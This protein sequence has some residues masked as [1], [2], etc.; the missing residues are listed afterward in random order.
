MKSSTILTGS[1]VGGVAMCSRKVNR[2]SRKAT[3]ETLGDRRLLAG[4]FPSVLD[5]GSTGSLREAIT[6]A[7]ANGQADEIRLGSGVYRLDLLAQGDLDVKD[8]GLAVR[9]V[10]SGRGQTVIDATRLGDRAFD[11]WEGAILELEGVTIL[12]G[13]MNDDGAG[14]RNAGTLILRDVEI[15]GGRANGDG[16]GIF[17][18]GTAH[19]QGVRLIGNAGQ[20]G[21]GLANGSE[22]QLVGDELEVLGNTAFWPPEYKKN[23]NFAFGVG[24]GVTNLGHMELS[25]V[26]FIFNRSDNFGGG[27]ENQGF[28]QMS[29]ALLTENSAPVGTAVYSYRASP[30]L[31]GEL[32]ETVLEDVTLRNNTS[33]WGRGS[34]EYRYATVSETNVVEDDGEAGILARDAAFSRRNK[35]S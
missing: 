25:H 16:G 26:E 15:A 35:I 28:L 8:I 20:R 5:D 13:E 3:F 10:G 11:V 1:H 32:A 19:L 33:A 30:S 29:H 6:V 2:T 31:G 22:G 9:I 34:I 18:S 4:F 27:L 14:I 24:G 21:G 23:F 12:A 17:N 7:A